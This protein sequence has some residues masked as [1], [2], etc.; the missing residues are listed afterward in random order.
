VDS[1]NVDD[2]AL[3]DD[4]DDD[5]DVVVSGGDDRADKKRF[6]LRNKR[7]GSLVGCIL[8]R[9]RSWVERPRRTMVTMVN[10]DGWNYE[11]PFFGY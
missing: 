9:S 11:M 10:N 5:D 4:D 7:F 3:V 1:C 6:W 8:P 2:T